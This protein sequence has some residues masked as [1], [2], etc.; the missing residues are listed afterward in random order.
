MERSTEAITKKT[1]ERAADET[2]ILWPWIINWS[3][4]WVAVVRNAKAS[5]PA[6][7]S[8]RQKLPLYK[9]GKT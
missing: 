8:D 3:P 7:A 4:S 1:L 9:N 5:D 2:H 6:S